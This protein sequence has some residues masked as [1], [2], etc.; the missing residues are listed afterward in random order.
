MKL[1]SK[2][3]ILPTYESR[4]HRINDQNYNIIITMITVVYVLFACIQIKYL[5]LG[6]TL[7]DGVTYSEY[8]VKGFRQLLAILAINVMIFVISPLTGEKKSYSF[9]LN[10]ILFLATCVIWVSCVMR[11]QLYIDV[12]QL[13]RMRLLPWTFSILLFILMTLVYL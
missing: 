13:T 6:G 5:F 2:Q 7:P 9:I 4:F 3:A 1:L 10:G 12:Y 8:A 11:L